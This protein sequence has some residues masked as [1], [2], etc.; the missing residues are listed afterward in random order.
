MIIIIMFALIAPLIWLLIWNRLHGE[1]Y[2]VNFKKIIDESKHPLLVRI[3]FVLYGAACITTA[4]I[5][6]VELRTGEPISGSTLGAL[7]LIVGIPAVLA[8]F[9]LMYRGSKK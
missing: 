5:A 2:E 9:Y 3:G 4:I 7:L 1:G 8:F 6:K